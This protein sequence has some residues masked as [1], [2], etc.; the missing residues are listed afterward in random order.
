[1]SDF[2]WKQKWLAITP[3]PFAALSVLG[4]LYISRQI[5]KS[6]T[7]RGEVLSRILLGLSLYDISTSTALFMGTW[8]IPRG[9]PGVFMAS[10]NDATCAAHG[11]FVQLGVGT[12]LYNASLAT[13]YFLAVRLGWKEHQLRRAEPL[14]HLVPVAFSFG[15]AIYSAASGLYANSNLW[16]WVDTSKDSAY[17]LAFMYGPVWAS[18]IIITIEMAAIVAHVLLIERRTRK[19]RPPGEG[20]RTSVVGRSEPGTANPAGASGSRGSAKRNGG[21]GGATK[22]V[23]TQALFYVFAFYMTWLFPSWTRMSQMIHGSSPFW[24]IALFCIFY[25][26]QGF[27]N[28]LVYLRPRYLKYRRDHPDYNI[29]QAARAIPRSSFVGAIRRSSFAGMRQSFSTGAAG[30]LDSNVGETNCPDPAAEEELRADE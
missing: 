3:K 18:M 4:S 11:F 13:Y 24:P 20:A 10:G 27:L 26:M 1:M 25:P 15:T 2:T 29:I 8:P 5:L 17:R 14:L 23:M 16:C 22:K 7:R 19:Y 6:P 9:A 30:P 12:P 28:C 21:G